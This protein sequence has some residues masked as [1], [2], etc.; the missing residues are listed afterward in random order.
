MRVGTRT[1]S[2]GFL[3]PESNWLQ[4]V[5]ISLRTQTAT[6]MVA[7]V[8]GIFGV[9]SSNIIESIKF[10]L[11][12]ADLRTKQ[13][14]EMATQISSY[15]FDSELTTEIIENNWTTREVMT[16]RVNEYNTAITTLRKNEFLYSAWL[17][18]Y[19]TKNASLDFDRFMISVREFDAAIHS[20]NDELEAV[21]IT[22]KKD[23]IDT[24][25]AQDVL[26]LMKSAVQKM[27]DD[28]RALL[29]SLS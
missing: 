18:K 17:H 25:R 1:A 16:E 28:G 15:I 2:G 13:Y 26:K 7:F 22:K 11:T 20:I 10:S 3:M 21:N 27:R 6:W 12:R 4:D 8:I 5:L 24:K 9:F 14:E 19:W 23:K 29:R